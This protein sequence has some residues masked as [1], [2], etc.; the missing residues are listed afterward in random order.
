[1]VDFRA[2]ISDPQTGKSYQVE[3]TGSQA[4]KFLGKRIGERI[5]GDAVGL[6]GYT[7][8]ITGGTD[9]DGFPMRPDLPGSKRKRLLISKSIGFKPEVKGLRRRKTLRGREISGEIGQINLVVTEYGSKTIEEIFNPPQEET[10]EDTA[11]G[12]G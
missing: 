7:L 5:E 6:P 4:N 8:K 9:R 2:I 10:G 1:M 3:I 12:E 11:E